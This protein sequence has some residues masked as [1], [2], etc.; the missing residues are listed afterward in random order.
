MSTTDRLGYSDYP[1]HLE[2]STAVGTAP[3]AKRERACG[4]YPPLARLPLRSISTR[5]G[6]L[7]IDGF[8]FFLETDAHVQ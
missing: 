6:E 7:V 5:N 8:G 1:P 2:I 3:V 4:R